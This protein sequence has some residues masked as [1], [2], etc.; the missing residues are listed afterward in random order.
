MLWLKRPPV[1][2]A[3]ETR[4]AKLVNDLR[5]AVANN[6][7]PTIDRALWSDFKEAFARQQLNRCGY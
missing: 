3:F 1:D 5:V 4:R 2:A 7:V 6:Q